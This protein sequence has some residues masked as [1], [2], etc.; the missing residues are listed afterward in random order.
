MD[1]GRLQYAFKTRV[2][3][4][5]LQDLLFY[6]SCEGFIILCLRVD[7]FIYSL[8]MVYYYWLNV[9]C[10]SVSCI[11]VIYKQLTVHEEMIDMK[12]TNT[13]LQ[14]FAERKI[15]VEFLRSFILL[16]GI[17]CGIN[18][19]QF[20]IMT[21]NVTNSYHHLSNF[22]AIRLTLSVRHGIYEIPYRTQN[23]RI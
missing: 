13:F 14:R 11:N 12:L 20:A 17:I 3:Y 23:K 19:Q 5:S 21:L 1:D 22:F 15:N 4:Y 9:D 7:Y 6:F 18:D 8:K 16:S 2:F 10:F